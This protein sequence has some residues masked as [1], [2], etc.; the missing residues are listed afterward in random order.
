[1]SASVCNA[2]TVF[3]ASG[4]SQIEFA[5][6][7]YGPEHPWWISM[8]IKSVFTGQSMNMP[9][10]TRT[11]GYVR[12]AVFVALALAWPMW[13]TRRLAKATAC[14]FALLLAVMAVSLALPILQVLEAVRV[15]SLGTLTQSIISIG[16]LTLVM[17]PSM[18]FA[19]PAL[20]WLLVVR[21]AHRPVGERKAG[22]TETDEGA[23]PQ[24]ARPPSVGEL[25]SRT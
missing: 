23:P 13:K 20:I 3:D 17:Y 5:P 4:D 12:I 11:L 22:L 24:D 16:I 21:L 18:A 6:Q 2:L 9:V 10:D 14:G 1:M 7:G 25:R 19:I 15:L 8:T